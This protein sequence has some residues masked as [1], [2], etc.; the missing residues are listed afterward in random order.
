MQ[1]HNPFGQPAAS[2]VDRLLGKSYHVVK[3]VYLNLPLLKEINSNEAIKFVAENFESI[4]LIEQNLDVLKNIS[5]SMDVL[6]DIPKIQKEIEQQKLDSLKAIS[7]AAQNE[8]KNLASV[9]KVIEA[10][11]NSY[12]QNL[13]ATL[14]NEAQQA[15]FSFRFSKQTLSSA[16]TYDVSLLQPQTNIKVGDHI[17]DDIGDIYQIIKLTE[18]SFTVGSR[19]TS[20]RGEKGLPGTGLN[21]LGVFDTYEDLIATKPIGKDGEAYSITDT[22]EV[23]VWDINKHSWQS[24]GSLKGAKGDPGL[25]ANEILMSP[26]PEKYFVQIYGQASG[27]IIDSLQ[28]VQPVV[29]P[30]PSNT[31]ENVLD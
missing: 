19:L 14:E 2:T 3:T 21:L 4:V 26:D 25:S 12:T 15:M 27:D 20:I 17:V 24:A 8:I 6:K 18:T 23:Y 29:S 10:N 16:N 1:S 7:T 9:Q 22:K 11:L 31:F 28:V 5:E 13:L 30:D